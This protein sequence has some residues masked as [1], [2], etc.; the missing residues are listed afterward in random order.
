MNAGAAQ[1]LLKTSGLA[2]EHGVFIGSGP[3]LY[4]VVRQYMLAGIPVTAVLDTTPRGNYW[5]ALP[6]ITGAIREYKNII[7]GQRWIAEIKKA[8]IP[9]IKNVKNVRCPQQ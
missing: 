8:G 3:L 1:I 7:K 4:L 2:A 6:H 5:R 9:F